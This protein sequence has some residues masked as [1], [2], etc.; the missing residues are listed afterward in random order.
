MIVSENGSFLNMA[1]PK[2]G[3]TM[4]KLV[5]NV[6]AT[7]FMPAKQKKIRYENKLHEEKVLLPP[8]DF[9]A[10]RSKLDKL[11]QVVRRTNP[12]EIQL[13]QS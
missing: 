11:K 12:S 4:A 3:T 7:D 10:W 2:Q 8:K 13:H 1:L 9:K 5:T 6:N